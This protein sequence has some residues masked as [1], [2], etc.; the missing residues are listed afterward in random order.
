VELEGE[1]LERLTEWIL[2]SPHGTDGDNQ[3]IMDFI[4]TLVDGSWKER[5][6]RQRDLAPRFGSEQHVVE[7]RVGLHPVL[8][9]DYDGEPGLVQVLAIL[10]Y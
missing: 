1:S 8:V 6:H 3:L 9:L 5:W 10:T 2:H 7:L 4:S